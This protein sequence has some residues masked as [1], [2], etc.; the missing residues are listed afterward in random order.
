MSSSTGKSETI[1]RSDLIHIARLALAG[2][3]DALVDALRT[4]PDARALAAAVTHHGLAPI[5]YSF[6]RRRAADLPPD[7]SDLLAA[8]YRQNKARSIILL[9]EAATIVAALEARGIPCIP[10]KGAALAEDLYGDPT[11]RPMTDVDLLVPHEAVPVAREVMLAAGFEEEEGDLREGFEEEFRCEI[12]FFRTVPFP[13]R[14]EIHWGLL[15]FGGHEAWTAEA[16]SRSVVTERGRRLTEED[17]LLYLAAHSAYHHQNDR[18]MWEFDV[19]LLLQAR[20]DALDHETVGDLAQRHRLLMP[21]RWALE[22]GERLGVPPPPHLALVAQ[23]RRVGR[24]ER[25]MLRYARDPQLASAVRTVL[26]I[27]STP[28]WR[29]RFRLIGAKMFPDRKHLETRHQ[30]RGFLPWIYLRRLAVLSA[31]LVSALFSRGKRS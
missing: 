4:V 29:R 10:L 17:T 20:G 12:S 7:L 18:L 26:T 21:F 3:S 16:I 14:I 1:P 9:G 31:R 19:A 23:N 5:L 28:G 30:A 24:V 22:T 25:W 11:L 2:R 27:R 8:S 6:T 13:A 15:N